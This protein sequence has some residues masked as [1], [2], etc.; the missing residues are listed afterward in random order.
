MRAYRNAAGRGAKKVGRDDF[1][2]AIDDFIPPHNKKDLRDME[3]LALR[4]C[5]SRK[6]IPKRVWEWAGGAS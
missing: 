4:Q 5:S 3:R 1:I 6:F 2:A